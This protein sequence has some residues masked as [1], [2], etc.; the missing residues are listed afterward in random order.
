[1]SDNDYLKKWNN[2]KIANLL[3]TVFF[4][5]SL[6]EITAEYNEDKYLIWMTKPLILPLLMAYYLRQSNQINRF[7]LIALF[8]CWIANLFFIENSWNYILLGVGF[9]L[10]YRILVISIVLKKTKMPSLLPMFIGI[11]PFVF[12]YASVAIFTFSTLGD[13]LYLFLIQ[14]VFTIFLGGFSLGNFMMAPNK[15]NRVLF[16]STM[17]FA[18]NQFVFLLRFYFE[19][20]NLFQAIAMIFFV[21]GQYLLTQYM[22]YTEKQKNRYIIVNKLSEVD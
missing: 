11:I 19:D 12:I 8:A 17:L 21:C 18:I 7:F 4:I 2:N 22:L 10:V 1:M 13:S 3:L 16:I 20:A 15:T 14:G 6:I 5:V 9:F